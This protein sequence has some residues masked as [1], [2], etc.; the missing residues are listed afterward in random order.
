MKKALAVLFLSITVL[1]QQPA[2]ETTATREQW[3]EYAF[4][5]TQIESLRN[6]A[7]AMRAQA[8]LADQE[9]N[10]LD[11]AI[12][13]MIDGFMKAAGLDPEKYEA[14]INAQEGRLFFRL[15]KQPK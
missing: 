7:E 15:R 12:K 3:L 6:K 4:K 9:A 10:R 8:V 2:G 11:A 13:P 14:M 5:M 1:G